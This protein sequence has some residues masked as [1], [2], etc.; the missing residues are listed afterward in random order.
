[1]SKNNTLGVVLFSTIS[2]NVMNI[3]ASTMDTGVH[4]KKTGVEGIQR[5]CS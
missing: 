4:R 1:M 3:P 2:V 5:R